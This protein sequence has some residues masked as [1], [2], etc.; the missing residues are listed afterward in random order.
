M[1]FYN[2]INDSSNFVISFTSDPKQDFGVFAKGYTLAAS[3]LAEQLLKKP[4]FADYKAYPVV[5]L[6]RHAFELYLK[7][8]YY[9][10]ML[11]SFF[12]NSQPV[13]C[14]G[15]YRHELI[16]LAITFQKICKFIFPEDIELLQLATKVLHFAKEFN[17]IDKI[18]YSYRY[19]I[20]TKGNASTKHHQC[21]NLR[22]THQAMKQ[23]LNE[24]NSVDFMFDAEAYKA[25]EVYEIMKEAQAMVVSP[26][27]ETC[28]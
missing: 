10:A 1:S 28:Q 14:Q 16:P 6:Y 9:Q 2:S 8:F 15:A 27:D 22:A 20:D 24:F 7:S 12:K 5:F 23:L 17:E 4:H 18:S 26:N 11:I 21:A 13:D 3:T 25:Q 19:P